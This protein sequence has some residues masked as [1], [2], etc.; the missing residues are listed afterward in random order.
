[1]PLPRILADPNTAEPPDYTSASYT[2]VCDAVA[3][4]Q[5][6]T[7]AEVAAN[8]LVAWNTENDTKKAAWEQQLQD[9]RNAEAVALQAQ[10]DIID[11]ETQQREAAERE[12]Q[13]EREKKRPKLNAMVPNRKMP[14]VIKHRPAQYTIRK[15]QDRE[16][17]ELSYFTPESRSDAS[18][19]DHTVA[20]AAYTLTEI[21]NVFALQPIGAY[22]AS[23]KVIPDAKLTW[24]QMTRA[25][26]SLLDWMEETGWDTAYTGPLAAFFLQ[27]ENHPRLQEQGGEAVLIAYQAHTR[28]AWHRALKDPSSKEAFDISAI[29]EETIAQ[30]DNRLTREEQQRAVTRS[31]TTTIL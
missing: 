18:R 20:D 11:A 23:K 9:D 14:T 15:L 7:A 19:L 10:Q 28:H 1:M 17:V 5:N 13:K 2:L 31:V 26:T 6:I 27:I 22:S 25:K 30:I 3:L 21:N 12:E 8:L 29:N 4:A 24:T 16:Y